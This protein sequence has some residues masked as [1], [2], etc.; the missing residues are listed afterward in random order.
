MPA[1][2]TDVG[3]DEG[4]GDLMGSDVGRPVGWAPSHNWMATRKSAESAVGEQIQRS[5]PGGQTERFVKLRP[6]A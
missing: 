3:L 4:G 2:Y 1:M 6:T 5:R